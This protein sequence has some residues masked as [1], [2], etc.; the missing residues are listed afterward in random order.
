MRVLS[1]NLIIGLITFLWVFP[2]LQLH[3]LAQGKGDTVE[4][5]I[6]FLKG[7][8]SATVK[9]VI[10][11]RMTSHVYKVGARAGQTLTVTFASPRKDVSICVIYPDG[12]SP[13]NGCGRGFKGTL[14]SDGDYSI[15]VDPRR[16]N[17]SYSLTVA[18][19]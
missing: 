4:R 9:G 5:R 12:S 7:R 10:T 8:S 11:D 15:L 14:P 17:T 18:I 16:E 2:A 3:S 6:K 13:D 19:R 1:R